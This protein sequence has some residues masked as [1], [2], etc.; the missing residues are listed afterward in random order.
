MQAFV[1]SKLSGI[2]G[3]L[4]IWRSATYSGFL[5]V[6]HQSVWDGVINYANKS[7]NDFQLIK[8]TLNWVG[9]S[10]R[11]IVRMPNI[12]PYFFWI[13]ANYDDGQQKRKAELNCSQLL[14]I[15]LFRS[16]DQHNSMCHPSKLDLKELIRWEEQI[17]ASWILILFKTT[18][19]LNVHN[20]GMLCQDSNH[21]AS[22]WALLRNV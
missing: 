17:W 9:E 2:S 19:K 11:N 18:E 14:N 10:V 8:R 7:W 20:Y 12:K 22:F 5:Q 16:L 6:Q 1:C 15:F 4:Q 21:F 13:T 3:Q